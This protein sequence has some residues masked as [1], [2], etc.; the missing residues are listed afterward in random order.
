M[1]RFRKQVARI[2]FSSLASQGFHICKGDSKDV[3]KPESTVE[4]S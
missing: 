3:D 1:V 2:F 4:H